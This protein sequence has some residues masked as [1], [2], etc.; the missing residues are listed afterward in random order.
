VI[1]EGPSYAFY[2]VGFAYVTSD[3]SDATTAREKLTIKVAVR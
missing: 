2:R 3:A 1:D